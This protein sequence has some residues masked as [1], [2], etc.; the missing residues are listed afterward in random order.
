M[1]EK[2]IVTLADDCNDALEEY[3][4]E[5]EWGSGGDRIT[6]TQGIEEEYIYEYLDEKGYS[7]EIAERVIQ[8]IYG[9]NKK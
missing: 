2:E 6:I 9:I 7:E 3:I 4:A 5:G 8:S 1:T